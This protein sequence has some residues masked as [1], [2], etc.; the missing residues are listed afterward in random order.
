VA[1]DEAAPSPEERC[2]DAARAHSDR[3]SV[4]GALTSPIVPA[5][6]YGLTF[7]IANPLIPLFVVA[8]GGGPGLVA[9]YS[10][11]GTATNA[12]TRPLV[13]RYSDRGNRNAVVSM[14]LIPGVVGLA[15]LSVVRVPWA[16]IPYGVMIG[17]GGASFW[18]SLRASAAEGATASLRKVL[19][20]LGSAQEAG[21]TLGQLAA[22]GLLGAVGF[23]GSFRIAAAVLLGAL[24]LSLARLR[25][26]RS[27]VDPARPAA[28]QRQE[29][30]ES[31]SM[32]RLQMIAACVVL[33][34]V[35]ASV[36]TF[37]PFLALY[38][39]HQLDAAAFL[40]GLTFALPRS[41]SKAA[42]L[43]ACSKGLTGPG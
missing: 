6:F 1:T 3:A 2:D 23:Q 8:S 16:V 20:R 12:V 4:A 19:G 43:T 30:H 24:S 7:G 21:T 10:I 38:V 26:R 28:A 25:I 22:G 39:R 27:A 18:P 40:V 13:G 32:P 14:A 41:C 11:V 35:G 15:A 31:A 34:L 37:L 42:I 33:G 36:S 17:I 29:P 9:A 5:A